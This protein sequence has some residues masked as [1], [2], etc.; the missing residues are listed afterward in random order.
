MRRF[1]PNQ[2]PFSSASDMATSD[3]IV[4]VVGNVNYLG[5][6][7]DT[8]PAYY[9]PFA[10]N[11]STRM[12][13]AV[14]SSGDAGPLSELLRREIHSID[15]G[16]TLAQIATMEQSLALSVSRPRFDTMLLAVFAG[17]ALLLAAVGITGSSLIR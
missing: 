8:G 2:D 9:M 14:R 1:L 15:P 13:L 3:G 10:Q 16:V 5:L 4:G 6:T 12:Y 17:I 7:V 11:Y